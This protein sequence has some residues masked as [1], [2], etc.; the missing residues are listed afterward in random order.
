MNSKRELRQVNL[1]T[2]HTIP[3]K[4]QQS[5]ID[6]WQVNTGV[7]LLKHQDIQFGVQEVQTKTN[8]ACELSNIR[9]NIESG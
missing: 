7:Q 6:N 3:Q 1:L 2:K 5:D 4:T 8:A 9:S